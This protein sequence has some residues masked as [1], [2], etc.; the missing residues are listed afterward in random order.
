MR[1][2]LAFATIAALSGC[3]NQQR[4]YKN[5]FI[6]AGTY[7]EV[8]SPYKEAAAIVEAEFRRLE[9]ILNDYDE[10]SQVSRLN[11]SY[12]RPI[13]V[14]PEMIEILQLSREYYDMTAGVFDVSCGRLY[15]LWKAEI[16][17]A[18]L[19]SLPPQ[20]AIALA[21]SDCGMDYIVVNPDQR[22]VRIN[23]KNLRL[24][25][26][27]LA[28]GYMVDKAVEKLRQH[29]IDSCLI[30]AGGQIY[31]LGKNSLASW[32]VGIR[33]PQNENQVAL[34]RELFN[35]AMSTSGG[36][37]QFFEFEGKPYSHIID[38]RSGYPAMP[39]L[40]S[41]T[42]IAENSALADAL[43][44]ACYV[45]GSTQMLELL[46]RAGKAKAIV[47]R[48]ENGKQKIEVLP[49]EQNKR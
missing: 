3:M 26:G 30:N 27:G 46:R 15:R 20:K 8:I 14:S 43:S 37:E 11:E 49:S 7:L 23:K 44:T 45:V 40:L 19:G 31:A 17:K 2:F 29:G 38:P 41:V 33:D 42:I 39:D 48:E 12:D 32:R 6:V 4:V 13:S 34:S 9:K 10:T 21:K 24:D 18:D 5:T 28:K 25:F 22:T 36:Y 16:E 1:M 35:E 47:I